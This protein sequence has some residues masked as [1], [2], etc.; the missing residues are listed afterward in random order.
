MKSKI[1]SIL[2][3]IL[4]LLSGFLSSKIWLNIPNNYVEKDFKNTNNEYHKYI[5][6]LVYPD[7]TIYKTKDKEVYVVDNFLWKTIIEEYVPENI[8]VKINSDKDIKVAKNS[9]IFKFTNI[10]TNT[11]FHILNIYPRKLNMSS[12][13]NKLIEEII[14]MLNDKNID[15]LISLKGREENIILSGGYIKDKEHIYNNIKNIVSF[16]RYI[17]KNKYVYYKENIYDIYVGNKLRVLDRLEEESLVESYI[18]IDI[19]YI[20]KFIKKENSKTYIYKDKILEINNN[21]LIYLLNSDIEIYNKRNVNMYTGLLR[22]IEFF[23]KQN[24]SLDNLVLKSVENK[25]KGRNLIYIYNFTYSIDDK[26]ILLG[27][28]NVKN[29]ITI[30]IGNNKIRKVV[31]YERN[32]IMDMK[33]TD[34]VNIVPLEDIIN[35]DPSI[36]LN[37][38][39]SIS[40]QYYDPCIKDIEEKLELVWVLKD[41]ENN[42]IIKN[43]EE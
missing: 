16:K 17:G 42:I 33:S 26:N 14:F 20:D 2:I 39:E 10:E 29:H 31:S 19:D 15:I 30:E 34:N 13:E 28:K 27:N 37:K 38:I 43:A 8:S 36:N 24:Y 5:K 21:G 25:V 12:I 1:K 41:S 23:R 40:L 11:I 3:I 7:S 6:K 32:Q 4:V 22:V 18:N 9:I 35:N